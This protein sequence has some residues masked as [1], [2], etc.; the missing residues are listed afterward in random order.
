MKN[1]KLS[2]FNWNSK[3]IENTSTEI[4]LFLFQDLQIKNFINNFFNK[5][6]LLVHQ[7][8]IYRSKKNLKI[9]ISFFITQKSTY[10]ISKLTKKNNIKNL[11]Q[12]IYNSLS[13][14][15]LEVLSNYLNC[16]Y[17]LTIIF[18]NL[19]KGL[20]LRLNN[21][22]SRIFRKKLFK[23]KKYYKLKCFSELINIF[24]I[25]IFKKNS[26]KILS[27]FIADLLTNNKRHNYF[28]NFIKE[29]F[30]SFIKSFLSKITG[31]KFIIK[32]RLNN[33]RRKSKK[34][35][36]IGEISLQS[37]NKKLSKSES[38]SFTSNGTI[39]VK[40]FISEK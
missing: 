8:V 20:S 28:F 36:Q 32:G 6:F 15:L 3:Y 10:F 30:S 1:F 34:I 23:L 16:K 25:T 27:E 33:K 14:K 35:L 18:Q 12:N 37:K 2:F 7:I 21:L 24:L 13:N 26:S 9:F 19:N 39:N 5:Y 29:F 31:L 17:N 38:T 40:V 22:K 4:S 11:N